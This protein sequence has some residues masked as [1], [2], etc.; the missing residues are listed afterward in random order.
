M[1]PKNKVKKYENI[2]FCI[3]CDMSLQNIQATKQGP[4]RRKMK[5][6]KDQKA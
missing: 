2:N 3:K 5:V 1:I 4:L 6:K